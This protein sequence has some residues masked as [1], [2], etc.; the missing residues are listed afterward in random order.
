MRRPRWLLAAVASV[1]SLLVAGVI[2]VGVA[3][4]YVRLTKVRVG[5]ETLRKKSLEYEAT[6]FAR[7]AFP[8]LAQDKWPTPSR[9]I[10]ISERGYR[11]KSFSVP[12]PPG[13]V[14]IVV[15]GGSSV[16]DPF[17]SEGR[18]WPHLLEE[19]LKAR[20]RPMVR[21]INGG[22]P[23]HATFDSLGRFYSEI[24]LY[25]P[26]YV[27]LYHGWNDIRYF[28]CLSRNNTL[29]RIYRPR[30]YEID[31]RS[32]IFLVPNPFIYYAGS[33]DRLL[34]HSQ[35]Y[36]RLR[37]RYLNWRVGT[38]RS[39]GVISEP[40]VRQDEYSSDA[41]RQF[42]LN[43]RLLVDAARHIGAIPVLATEA[44]LVT[45]SH[46]PHETWK[47][48]YEFVRLSH[49]ALVR[50]Y[51]DCDR[52]VFAV[53]RAQGVPV[54]DTSALLSGRADFF[55]DH[56]HTT[57]AG[58]EALAHAAADF[59]AALMEHPPSRPK[60]RDLG[61]AMD[62]RYAGG[63]RRSKEVGRVQKARRAMAGRVS[64]GN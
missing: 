42:E 43:L 11:G 64:Y 30:P 31:R 48:G 34:S 51:T 29:L 41:P 57:T 63:E 18:D 15:L 60:V 52:A 47:I 25:E 16:F 21:V 33:I 50:A 3:E 32:R 40:E 59:L 23:G 49:R 61:G 27:L 38:P 56:V 5:P 55:E 1:V 46:S 35:V 58:S 4:V 2:A 37:Y 24:W 45:P 12:K 19:H 9:H 10:A 53:G 6:L 22:I 8:K 36:V 39:E 54:L 28:C 14:R 62:D 26:D 7:H 13:E 44:R 20:G 17:A